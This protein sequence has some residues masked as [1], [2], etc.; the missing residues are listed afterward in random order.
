[1]YQ[2]H[3]TV[4]EFASV[5]RVH[6]SFSLSQENGSVRQFGTHELWIEPPARDEDPLWSALEVLR[7]ACVV[8][9]RPNR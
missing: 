3:V 5:W 1:M 6:F 8:E 7:R 2:L 9:L 4:Q